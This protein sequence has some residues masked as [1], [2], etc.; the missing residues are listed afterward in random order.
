M[1]YTRG[2][3]KKDEVSKNGYLSLIS[4]IDQADFLEKEFE[5]LIQVIIS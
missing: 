2:A 4:E 1:V 3:K 5:E